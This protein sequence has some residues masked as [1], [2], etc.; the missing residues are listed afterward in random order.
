MSTEFLAS[1]SDSDVCEEYEAFPS[2]F[3]DG[4]FPGIVSLEAIDN[5]AEIDPDDRTENLAATVAD[6]NPNLDPDT[7]CN[8]LLAL[9]HTEW[10]RRSDDQRATVIDYAGRL[11]KPL[12]LKVVSGDQG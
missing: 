12:G 7:V 1:Q 6:D 10:A 11:L 9:T 3:S 2:I 5:L 4:R 8:V